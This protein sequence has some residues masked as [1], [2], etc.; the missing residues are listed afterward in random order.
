MLAV[1]LAVSVTVTIIGTR[2]GRAEWLAWPGYVW[3]GLMFYLLVTL[4]VVE[5]PRTGLLLLWWWRSRTGEGAG[6]TASA[7]AATAADP[8]R[9]FRRVN[10][11]MGSNDMES[12]G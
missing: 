1:L 8:A 5:V 4:V 6:E 7:T 11:A 3:I 10:D 2:T 12:S 9:N